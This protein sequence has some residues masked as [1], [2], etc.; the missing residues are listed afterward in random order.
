MKV[1]F[2][3]TLLIFS[4]SC[5][6]QS[7]FSTRQEN[8]NKRASGEEWQPDRVIDTLHIQKGWYIGDLGAGGGY[9]T[10][11]FAEETGPQGM[12]YAADIND[13]FLEAIQKEAQNKGLANV[14]T[15]L[16]SENDSKFADNSLDMIFIRNA[17]HHLTDRKAYMKRLLHK[18]KAGGHIVI[19]DYKE[20]TATY[21]GHSVSR[22]DI[23]SAIADSGL[24]IVN[25]FDFL[26]KQ[27][28]FILG[29]KE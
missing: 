15:I 9:Y 10:F 1:F 12:V 4:V 18:L 25:E 14:S 16:S 2:F 13:D 8:Y 27:Y 5:R 19:I 6:A 22:E 29:M 3:I 23:L 7:P 11:R 21:P 24:Q 28:F 26:E 17:F 20:K